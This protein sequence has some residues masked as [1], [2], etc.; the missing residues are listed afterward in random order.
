MRMPTSL[1]FP[2]NVWILGAVNMDETTHHLSPKVLDRVHVLRFGNPMLADWE[3]IE[4]E[5]ANGTEDPGL[6]L[7]LAPNEIGRRSDYPT[8][9]RRDEAAAFLAGIARD[10]LDPLGI[11]FGLRAVRQ[12]QG[13]LN[14]AE[15]AGIAPDQALDNVVRQKILPKIALDTS[16]PTADGRK[17]G[18]VLVA[19]RDA[20]A[21]RLGNPRA[22]SDGE[23][24]VKALNR[25][26]TLADGNNRV[27]NYWMR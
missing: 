9:D 13:Y 1:R 16:R 6:T 10:Y 27:A 12:S 3:A 8:F 4:A 26:I 2:E 25:L 20:L 11:E 7:T 14:A 18:A 17:R 15:L 5:I 23:N 19:L 22:G 24:S 21:D